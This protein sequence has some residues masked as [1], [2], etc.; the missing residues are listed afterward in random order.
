VLGLTTSLGVV[1]SGSGLGLGS[2]GSGCIGS[3]YSWK[4]LGLLGLGAEDYL[5]TPAESH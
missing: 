5:S 3:V 1:S 4:E 2:I